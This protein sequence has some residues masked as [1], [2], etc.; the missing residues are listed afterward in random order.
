[1][2]LRVQLSARS[3][4]AFESGGGGELINSPR[5]SAKMQ[6]LI[7]SS[8]LVVNVFD[9]WVG[10]TDIGP[11]LHALNIDVDGG[12]VDL[13]AK[14]PTG[15][16]G[17]PPNLDAAIT[18][19]SGKVIG[20]EG[21][22]TEWTSPKTSKQSPFKDKYF[23][24]GPGLWEQAGLPR[25]QK[26]AQKIQTF[27]IVFQHLDTAQLLKHALGLA[28]KS[29][30]RFQLLYLYFD[31]AGASGDL[32]QRELRKFEAL[33]DGILGFRAITYQEVICRLAADP[34]VPDRDYI[35]YLVKRYCPPNGQQ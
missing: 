8:A 4:R 30:G 15:L 28:T 23:P 29:G 12:I 13:E 27:E 31:W 19:P 35:Q 20:I 33:V 17:E 5:R 11:L 34:S 25:C 16:P 14:M 10:R 3:K 26:L 18:L 6:A 7:S 2:N 21:K 9:P 32:H 24:K 22:F 1:M